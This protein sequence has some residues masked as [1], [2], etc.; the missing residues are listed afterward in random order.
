MVDHQKLD[1][2]WNSIL[3]KGNSQ[4][5]LDSNAQI[6]LFT[7]A[8]TKGCGTFYQGKWIYGT[9]DGWFFKQ[10][11]PF[12]ELFAIVAAV[13][14]W[15]SNWSGFPNVAQILAMSRALTPAMALFYDY[16]INTVPCLT[17]M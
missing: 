15:G 1:H 8:C 13:A 12:K 17:A 14:T 16:C 2:L 11:M 10:S 3:Q 7:D 4:P 6:A 9:F 5:H